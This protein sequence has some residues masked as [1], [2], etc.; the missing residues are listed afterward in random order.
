MVR[1]GRCGTGGKEPR[2][3]RRQD[4]QAGGSGRALATSLAVP[5]VSL[6]LALAALLA[7]AAGASAHVG[8]LPGEA[9]PGVSQ[10][11]TVRVP[12]ERDVPTTVVRVDFPDG[13]VVSRFQP[14][15]GWQR[16][17]Q[18]SPQGQISSVTWSGGRIDPGEYEDFN[19]VARTPAQ[20]GKLSFKAY[21]T[22]QGGEVVEWVQAENGSQPA[23]VM[24][25]KAGPQAA[26]GTA[27]P[28][29]H[30]RTVAAGGS[31]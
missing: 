25:V 9:P 7:A 4:G 26:S 22:Y 13:L 21:Q 18:R 16:E 11:F 8:V 1:A 3:M 17:V 5:V 10:A 12:T 14:K 28:D 15:P 2:V 31:V 6:V 20:P 27:A 24:E 23:A 19:F 29:E 30:G